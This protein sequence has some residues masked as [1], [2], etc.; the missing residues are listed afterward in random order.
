MT[1]DTSEHQLH[2]LWP[3]DRFESAPVVNL[4]QGYALRTFKTEDA[5]AMVT[6]MRLA[7]FEEW[8]EETLRGALQK[9]PPEG[10]FFAVHQATGTLTATAMATHNPLELHPFGGELGWVGADPEHTGKALGAVVCA[11][12]TE[13]FLQAGYKRIYIRTDDWRLPAIKTYLKLGYVPFLYQSDMEHRWRSVCE[14]LC[15]PFSPDD[16]PQEY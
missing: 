3:M 6:L 9:A 4:P 10:I 1:D 12:V 15:W 11:A 7:G 13:R 2:M 5:E 8:N 16:W 14:K